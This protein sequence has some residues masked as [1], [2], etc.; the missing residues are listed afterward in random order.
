MP[1]V[2]DEQETSQ[3]HDL[4]MVYNA[5]PSVNIH[6]QRF[7]VGNWAC[8]GMSNARDSP[9]LPNVQRTFHPDSW[10]HCT[11]WAVTPRIV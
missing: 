10:C 2:R 6:T 3:L 11:A 5:P 7:G 8:I 9:S 4:H 1:R